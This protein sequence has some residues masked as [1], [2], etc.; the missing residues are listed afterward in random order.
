MSDNTVIPGTPTV[1]V[2]KLADPSYVF[3]AIGE[4]D[5]RRAAGVLLSDLTDALAAHFPVKVVPADS[6]VIER[7]DLFE[8][9]P[10][11]SVVVEGHG[12]NG[13]YTYWLAGDEDPMKAALAYLS[14]A[15]SQAARVSEAQVRA[16]ASDLAL[17][18]GVPND[19]DAVARVLVAQGWTRQEPTP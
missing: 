10:D 1:V 14:I 2:G 8:V 11:G 3:L 6:I 5:R 7:G 9:R 17:A 16:L 19:S 18:M 15:A 4:S 12:P 13:D